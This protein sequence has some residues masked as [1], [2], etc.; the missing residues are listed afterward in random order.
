MVELDGVTVTLGHH[1]SWG[2][3]DELCDAYDQAVELVT[4]PGLYDYDR[5]TSVG[6]R[7]AKLYG[8]DDLIRSWLTKQDNDGMARF[9]QNERDAA[10]NY[11]SIL[12][13]YDSV[14]AQISTIRAAR[15]GG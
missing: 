6:R 7:V 9:F 14:M 8:E 12:L 1:P 3:V 11:H 13:A 10:S 2:T 15:L 4:R 5:D